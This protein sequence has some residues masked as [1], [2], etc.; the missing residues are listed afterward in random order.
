MQ[1][2]SF[3]F[4]IIGLTFPWLSTGVFI[5]TDDAF[6]LKVIVVFITSITAFSFNYFRIK[7]S[8]LYILILLM[9]Y[10]LLLY[11]FDERANWSMYHFINLIFLG[12]VFVSLIYSELEISYI[13]KITRSSIYILLAFYT[14]CIGYYNIHEQHMIN[15]LRPHGAL[16]LVFFYLFLGI[17]IGPILIGLIS[18]YTVIFLTFYY[19]SRIDFVLLVILLVTYY[20]NFINKYFGFTI[21]LLISI[22]LA[23]RER[24]TSLG[25][26][27][28]GRNDINE[29]VL[30]YFDKLPLF[31]YGMELDNCKMHGYFHSS[32]YPL[33]E[34]FG[35]MP[36]ILI[37]LFLIL[38]LYIVSLKDK[39]FTRFLY[40]SG[41]CL[42]GAVEGGVEMHLILSAILVISY[43]IKRPLY[44]FR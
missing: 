25:F 8:A 2:L 30:S 9:I 27:S 20:K 12:F 5:T 34:F 24:L 36:F 33:L 39:C 38:S 4:L 21:A 35:V 44:E 22:F 3:L 13:E 11:V 19:F 18:L 17:R 37:I 23:T 10:S 43:K 14:F 42:Y 41:L 29:C 7:E 1:H 40:L 6:R 32:Y 16:V 26:T 15:A 28:S 31:G